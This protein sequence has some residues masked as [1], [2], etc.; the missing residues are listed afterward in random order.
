MADVPDYRE[1]TLVAVPQPASVPVLAPPGRT[2]ATNSRLLYDV[3][4]GVY[5]WL[6]FDAVADRV[7]RDLV[8]ARIV[9][10]T[11][12]LDVN[13]VLTDVGANTVSY[14]TIQRHLDQMGPKKYRDQIAEKCFA[15]ARDCGGLSLL[16][17]DVTTLYFEAE[18]EDDLRKVGFSNYAEVGV[19][20]RSW[21]PRTPACSR[22]PT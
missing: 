9:E 5:D 2:T 8:I 18:N 22:H 3:I 4:G 11:S 7:F 14:R 13:R 19:V 17:Y 6:G 10:P 21:W 12:K 20:P 16:L 1:P 15:Y